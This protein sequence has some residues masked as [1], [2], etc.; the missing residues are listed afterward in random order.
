M[1]PIASHPSAVPFLPPTAPLPY[2]SI[3]FHKPRRRLR[4]STASV[5]VVVVVVVVVGKATNYSP[6]KP[7]QRKRLAASDRA[8][9]PVISQ[10]LPFSSSLQ[11]GSDRGS[12]HQAAQQASTCSWC[13]P[14]NRVPRYQTSDQS[15]P[16]QSTIV[17]QTAEIYDHG[18]AEKRNKLRLQ[19]PTW[20]L[21]AFFGCRVEVCEKGL[22]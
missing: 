6:S 8:P 15:P 7:Q 17:L 9:T 5:F 14:S 1:C 11:L 21:A 4:L 19:G 16:R 3:Q 18:P 10:V 22:A 2:H 12:S 13:S 20:P